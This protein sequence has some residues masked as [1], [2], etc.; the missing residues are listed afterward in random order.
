MATNAVSMR[1][2]FSETWLSL[3]FEL[4]KHLKRRRLLI[5]GALA[6]LLPLFPLIRRPDTALEFAGSSL[7][8]I[9]VLI[10]IS[11]AMFAGDAV[12]GEFEK[13]TSLLLFPT[14]QNRA[15]IFAGKYLA[16]LLCTFLVVALWYVVLT[17]EIG[18]LYGWGEMPADLWKSLMTALLFSAA[19]VG[20]AF[21]VSSFF[22]RSISAT[23]LVFLILMMI[24]PIGVMIMTML[25][26]EPW[27][28]VTYSA[29]LITSVLGVSNRLPMAHGDVAQQFTP[30]LGRGIAVM[31][32]YAVACL[33]AGMAI[34]V[35]KED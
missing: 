32:T 12:C 8:F 11:A 26:T 16:A 13:K 15:S 3:R 2:S 25:D 6:V 1:D 5:L 31:V 27:F 20:L 21:L 19:A 33:G 9:S 30:T 22:K 28:I 23:I 24:L 17:L 7:N 35:R 4:L 10:V 18:P 34:A 29:N 14:P